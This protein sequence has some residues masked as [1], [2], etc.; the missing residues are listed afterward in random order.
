MSEKISIGHNDEYRIIEINSIPI[1]IPISLIP[2]LGLSPTSIATS[3]EQKFFSGLKSFLRSGD[4]VLEI[5]SSLGIISALM[6][7]WI[8][9]KGNVISFEEEEKFC[10][11]TE[12][13]CRI[14]NLEN[15]KIN[16]FNPRSF[17][18]CEFFDNSKVKPT[19]I[20]L[21]MSHEKMIEISMIKELVASFSPK[22][23]LKVGQFQEKESK[24]IL[25][26]INYLQNENYSIFDLQLG[27]NIRKSHTDNSLNQGAI[28]LLSKNMSDEFT[29]YLKE[30]ITPEVRHSK[31]SENIEYDIYEIRKLVASQNYNEV[32]TL[33]SQMPLEGYDAEIQYLIG[34]S[35]QMTSK[36]YTEILLRYDAA[37]KGG[38]DPFWIYYNKSNLYYLMGNLDSTIKNLKQAFDL[39]PNHEGV[40]SMM[41]NLSIDN[42]N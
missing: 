13:I 28:L 19:C 32:I 15:V 14:N 2:V 31:S 39:N 1:K 35:L 41:K 36:N 10:E 38:F 9:K 16:R 27:D 33:L 5:G 21:E 8:G 22:I 3:Y 37:L 18:F 29:R 17:N 23:V 34:F 20:K 6:A 12:I 24:E 42:F 7:K 40:L 4:T 11:I 30:E 26:F 25:E